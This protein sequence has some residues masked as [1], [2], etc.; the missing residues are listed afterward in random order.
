MQTEPYKI[1]HRSSQVKRVNVAEC[2][3]DQIDVEPVAQSI[4]QVQ[5]DST[6]FLAFLKRTEP[7]MHEQLSKNARSRA[8]KNLPA[9]NSNLPYLSHIA[10]FE[11]EQKEQNE[12]FSVTNLSWNCTGSLLAVAYG[13]VSHDGWCVHSGLLTCWNVS[14]R[15]HNE[16]DHRVDANACVTSLRF[17]PV[18][19]SVLVAGTFTGELLVCD[20]ALDSEIVIA[21]T[22]SNESGHLEAIN[23]I[24]WLSRAGA[25]HTLTDVRVSLL[26]QSMIEQI[27]T[28]GSDGRV[29]CWSFDL[30]NGTSSLKCI[31]IFQ[32]RNSDQMAPLMSI[33]IGHQ[34]V[35]KSSLSTIHGERSVSLTTAALS[36]HQV[37]RFVVGTD[38]GGVLLCNLEA[39]RLPG[40]VDP[41]TNSHHPS[42]VEFSLARQIGP[43]N[44]VDWSKFHRNLIL[45][46]GTG[47]TV[48][49]HNALQ[50]DLSVTLDLGKGTV[51]VAQFSPHYP[52]LVGCGT[53]TGAIMFYNLVGSHGQFGA[54]DSPDVTPKLVIMTGGTE[55]L[56]ERDQAPILSLA[57]NTQNPIMLATGDQA[58]RVRLWEIKGL[59]DEFS[60]ITDLSV[61]DKLFL[62]ST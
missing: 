23:H 18:I 21:N 37:G 22:G 11:V 48:H 52:N 14:R 54:A 5:M 46:C 55:E 41:R 47:S 61:I 12:T 20:F 3:T 58:G 62:S 36:P 7:I 29:V 34:A 26:R 56:V 49:I 30:H 60:M 50:R 33:H 45:S 27:L 32:I 38:S 4:G 16:P 42:P 17:H 2:Q 9:D 10:L 15:T 8:F 40:S 28:I 51:F 1:Y 6:Q 57:F 31:K 53:E 25:G 59:S 44:S 24:E 35:R 39:E 43:I 19:P 13:S